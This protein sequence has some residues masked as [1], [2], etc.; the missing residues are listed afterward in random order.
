[1]KHL[2]WGQ[3]L[4]PATKNIHVSKPLDTVAVQISQLGVAAPTTAEV[5]PFQRH[6]MPI[7]REVIAL[8]D[9][10]SQEHLSKAATHVSIGN[11]IN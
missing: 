3:F 8:S 1:M 4:L 2:V 7:R 6:C 9:C 11:L 5:S 10:P